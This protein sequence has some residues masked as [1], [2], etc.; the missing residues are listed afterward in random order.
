MEGRY[1]G[2]GAVNGGGGAVNGGAVLGG[3]CNSHTWHATA[4]FKHCFKLHPHTGHIA[5]ECLT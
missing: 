3:D 1:W 4:A 5:K 2:G